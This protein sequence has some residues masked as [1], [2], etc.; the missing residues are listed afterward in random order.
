[1]GSGPL[2]QLARYCSRSPSVYSFENRLDRVW[3]QQ[4]LKYDF[5]DIIKKLD[6]QVLNATRTTDAELELNLSIEN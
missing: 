4:N 6:L 1:M 2:E 3:A 5:E